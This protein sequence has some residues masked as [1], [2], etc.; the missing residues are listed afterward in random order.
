[1][2]TPLRTEPLDRLHLPPPHDKQGENFSDGNQT[3]YS[4]PTGGIQRRQVRQARDSFMHHSSDTSSSI[5]RLK[6]AKNAFWIPRTR[7]MATCA[8]AGREKKERAI[9]SE[10]GDREHHGQEWMNTSSIVLTGAR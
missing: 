1:M 10:T 9:E 3:G 4:A 6:V 5:C 7:G 2:V 8:Q